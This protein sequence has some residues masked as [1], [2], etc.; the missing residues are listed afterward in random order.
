[1]L[2][3]A[4]SYNATANQL[5]IYCNDCNEERTTIALNDATGRQ[6]YSSSFA[7]P[8]FT[9]AT[10]ALARGMYTMRLKYANNMET[11]KVVIY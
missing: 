11:F 10:D 2:W 9:I 8:N 7:T 5:T 1:M 4:W 3:F 6:I